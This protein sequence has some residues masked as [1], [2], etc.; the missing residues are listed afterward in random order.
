MSHSPTR[1]LATISLRAL[2]SVALFV[3]LT[4]STSVLTSAAILHTSVPDPASPSSRGLLPEYA[5]SVANT[6]V[7]PLAALPPSDVVM[8]VDG[9]R[10]FGE[11]IPRTLAGQQDI[12]EQFKAALQET[13]DVTGLDPREMNRIATGVRFRQPSAVT[14][15]A[16]LSSWVSITR[17][18][19]YGKWLAH[20]RQHRPGVLKESR[21][22]GKTFHVLKFN[23]SEKR[24]VAPVVLLPLEGSELAVAALD[25]DTIAFGSLVEV[26]LALDAGAGGGARVSA[27]LVA[28]ATRIPDALI[29][30]AGLVPPQFMADLLSNKTLAGSELGKALSSLTQFSAAVE[31]T[32]VTLIVTTRGSAGSAELAKT[33]GDVMTALKTLAGITPVKTARDKTNREILKG[34]TISTV[35]PEVHVRAEFTQATVTTLARQ[36]TAGIYNASGLAHKDMGD[37]KAALADY[38]RAIALDPDGATAYTNRGRVRANEGDFAAALA[39]Y[40]KAVTL[41]PENSTVYNNRGFTR[42]EK[43]DLDGAIADLDK[44]IALDPGQAYAYNNRGRALFKKGNLSDALN[45]YDRS[46]ALNPNNALAYSNRGFARYQQGELDRALA[47]FDK[48][49]AIN[50]KLAEAYTGRGFAR[51]DQGDNDGAVADF[52]T[53]VA[54]DPKSVDAYNGRGLTRYSKGEW[55]GAISDF[56]RALAL[57][58]DDA[59]VYTNR[60]AARTGKGAFEAAVADFNKAI[61]LRP[62]LAEAYNGRGTALYEQGNS[63]EAIADLNKAIAIRPDYAEAYGQRALAR[64]AL[65]RDAEAALDLKKCLELDATLQSIYATLAEEVMKTR[66]DKRRRPH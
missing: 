34:L 9:K 43:G 41:D 55:D 23:E 65:G 54:L 61:V 53:S 3:P 10:F 14:G 40:D 17:G 28:A 49:I 36:F 59:A 62:D 33:I 21:H 57:D 12:V 13:K 5:P 24:M 50:P 44:A 8:F 47:D 38:D 11:V 48:A 15:Q 29:G 35:G 42:I 7:D 2:L 46:L 56:D 25:A 32:P 39:D 19:D 63:V 58:P 16:E 1:R 30:M 60:G 26:R 64:L 18:V 22:G 4:P 20:V 51:A 52:D 31:L 45:D 6:D 37:L 27:Q 66:R